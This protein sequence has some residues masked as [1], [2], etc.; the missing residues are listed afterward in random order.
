MQ[1]TCPWCGPRDVEEFTYGGDALA[2]RPGFDDLSPDAWHSY[3]F[4]RNNLRGAHSEFWHHE[5]GC[6]QWLIVTRDT[7]DHAILASKPAR[8]EAP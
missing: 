8:E 3:L 7:S 1:L 5:A 6:R 2:P 4:E